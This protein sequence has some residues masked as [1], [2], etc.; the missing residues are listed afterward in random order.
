MKSDFF[1][2]ASLNSEKIRTLSL[3]IA[4]AV[5]LTIGTLRTILIGQAYQLKEFT[6]LYLIAVIS[7]AV[8]F[9]VLSLFKKSVHAKKKV[10]MWAWIITTIFEVSIPTVILVIVTNSEVIGPYRALVAPAALLFLYFIMLAILRMHPFLVILTGL[11]SALGY[12][13]V[14]YYTYSK[15]PLHDAQN[16][17]PLN[18][19][20]TYGLFLFFGSVVGAG[21]AQQLKKFV[22]TALK[23]SQTRSK[24]ERDLD[25]ARTI[26][27]SLLPQTKP[28][29]DDFDIAGW[30]QPANQTG[31]DYYDWQA[32]SENKLAISLADVSGHGIGPAL[33]TAVCRAYARANFASHKVMGEIFDCINE[34]LV[35]DLPSNRFITFV[36]GLLN[37]TDSKLELLSAGHGP[38]LFYSS[39]E[40]AVHNINAH[41]IPLGIASNIGY[42]PAQEILL[43][44]GDLIVLITDGFFEWINKDGEQYGIERLQEMIIQKNQLPAQELIN[45]IYQ[46]V[47]TFS[48]GTPQEDDLTAVVIKRM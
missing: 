4:F 13:M 2:Q 38:V 22:I 31:G 12:F 30:S 26:Q 6:P 11:L 23:E 44:S 9:W 17:F 5:L 36:V 3:A 10:P 41:N 37:C 21:V 8:E 14:V 48:G 16:I 32:V 43:Q 28:D 42:G 39:H 25:I 47:L 34:L 19:Y 45:T 35:E 24:L 1:Q 33:V 27:Q 18:I 40:K 15:Y 29:I 46:D 20:V 7:M